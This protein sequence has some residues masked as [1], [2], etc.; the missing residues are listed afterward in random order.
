MKV[1]VTWTI[2]VYTR[3][4]VVKVWVNCLWR[5]L[6]LRLGPENVRYSQFHVFLFFFFLGFGSEKQ[7]GS[8][9]TG[10]FCLMSFGTHLC[11]KLVLTLLINGDQH[12]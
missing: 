3:T 4:H 6:S 5:G 12:V 2:S 8:S 7:H 10:T 9:K 11:Q 1:N